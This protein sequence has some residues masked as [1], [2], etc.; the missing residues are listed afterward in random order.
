MT[1]EQVFRPAVSQELAIAELFA[2]AGGQFDPELVPRF[3]EFCR[4]DQVAA[5]KEA[6][7]RWLQTLDPR[8]VE[9]YWRLHHAPTPEGQ[10]DRKRIF[11]TR[12]LDNMHD[13]VIFVDAEFT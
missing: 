8:A 3:A 9:H 12:L 4:E 11:E 1:N 6:S 2:C 5:R 7:H 10:L 13:A